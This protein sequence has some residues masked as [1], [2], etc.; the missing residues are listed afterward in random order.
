MSSVLSNLGNRSQ[1]LGPNGV[2]EVPE[3]ACLSLW[4]PTCG[5]QPIAWGTLARDYDRVLT[6]GPALEQSGE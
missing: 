3:A 2:E 4:A 5:K 6:A 1:P